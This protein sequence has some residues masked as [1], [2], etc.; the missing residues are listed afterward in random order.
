MVEHL[1]NHYQGEIMKLIKLCL[2]I[3]FGILKPNFYQCIVF[4]IKRNFRPPDDIPKQLYGDLGENRGTLSSSNLTNTPTSA[5][6]IINLNIGPPP[7][8]AP[9]APPKKRNACNVQNDNETYF[10]ST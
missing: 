9:P 8:C 2:E 6:A 4:W 7:A 1:L 5:S 10:G 3:I